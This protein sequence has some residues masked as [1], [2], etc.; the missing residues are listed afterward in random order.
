ML[1]LFFFISSQILLRE[2]LTTNDIQ[3]AAEIIANATAEVEVF[4]RKPS[5]LWR[6][7][8]FLESVVARKD[9]SIEVGFKHLLYMT[10]TVQSYFQKLHLLRTVRLKTVCLVA[11]FMSVDFERVSYGL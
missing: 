9:P 1:H 5:S 4:E 10:L 7:L 8:T 2:H 6:I 11:F 3:M